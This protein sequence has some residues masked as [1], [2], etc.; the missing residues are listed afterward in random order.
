ML[1]IGY[2]REAFFICLKWIVSYGKEESGKY[3]TGEILS[4]RGRCAY[5]K[6]NQKKVL[7][8]STRKVKN[9]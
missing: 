3:P 7:E 2:I 4:Y 6:E 5:K 1:C 9:H 8:Q